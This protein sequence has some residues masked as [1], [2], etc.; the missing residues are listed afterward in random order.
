M[1][2]ICTKYDIEEI[3]A[4]TVNSAGYKETTSHQY[5][6]SLQISIFVSDTIK[7]LKRRHKLK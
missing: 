5:L 1:M 6:H 7:G 2:N 3:P 4:M